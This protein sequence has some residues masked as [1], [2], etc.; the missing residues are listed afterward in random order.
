VRFVVVCLICCFLPAYA[1]VQN[2]HQEQLIEKR[3]EELKKQLSQIRREQVD[4]VVE[5]QEYMIADWDKYSKQ[6]ELIRKLEEEERTIQE[7]ID[8]L[9]ERKMQFSKQDR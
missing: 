9:E 6:V 1:W 3:I 8:R 4:E 5:S 2:N 7:E